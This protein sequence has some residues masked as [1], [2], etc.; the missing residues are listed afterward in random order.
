MVDIMGRIAE[1]HRSH[2]D[3]GAAETLYFEMMTRYYR[4]MQS[5]HKKGRLL[6]AHSTMLP[7]ELFQVM[8]IVPM[9]MET[10][11]TATVA[12]L[13]NQE[14]VLGLARAAGW[15]GGICSSHLVQAAMISKG[16]LPRPD[17]VVW[18]SNVC[19]P[20]SKSGQ[21][22]RDV[23]GVPGFFVDRPY[24]ASDRDREYYAREL[25]EMVEFL[26]RLAGRRMD[27]DRLRRALETTREMSRL[28]QE[29]AGLRGA[30]PCPMSNRQGTLTSVIGSVWAGTEE[31]LNYMRTV[32]DGLRAGV[33]N[34][35]GFAHQEK[36][37]LVQLFPPPAHA[38]KIMEW[39]ERE[40]GA[41][42][43][44]EPFATGWGDW[45]VNPDD[46]MGSLAGK[47]F[48]MPNSRQLHGPACE[49]ALPEIVGQALR[50]KATGAIYWANVTCPHSLG[51][52]RL[53]TDALRERAGIPTLVLYS[54]MID[55][56]GVSSEDVKVQIEGFLEKLVGARGQIGN[57][58]H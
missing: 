36:H 18:G 42:I 3:G 9:Q 48:A 47:S 46:L 17:A 37:R 5:A 54:D 25:A 56:S 8:D 4:R 1:R 26:E 28:H 40:Q 19:D 55:P 6:V 15:G 52:I 35:T 22:M 53:A 43:V 20:N 34:G 23:Y 13:K 30:R 44:S 21:V 45:G 38:M 33:E 7:V 29:I 27:P 58:K 12:T 24:G 2:P 32:R 11:T 41:V 14:E 10:T 39:M 51:L 57:P 31:G 16:W 50:H 49:A